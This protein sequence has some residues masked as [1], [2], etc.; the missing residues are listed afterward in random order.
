MNHFEASDGA[1]IAYE[2]TG[3]GRPLVMLHG[4]MAHGGFFS[5]Q[6][7]LAGNFRL[8]AV[9]LRGH[10]GSRAAGQRPSV[11]QIASDV[12]ALA[13]RLDLQGAI[14]VGW[15]LG[16][17]IL[18]QL[19]AGAASPRFAGA[20]V[21]DMTPRV[22][23]EGDWRLGLSADLVK[24][25]TAA[26]R[27]DYANFAVA[28]GSAIFAQPVADG[29]REIAVWAGEQF[30]MNDPAAMSALWASLVEK[31]FRALLPR[32]QQPTLIVHGA[33]S[34]LYRAETAHFIAQALPRGRAIAF[35]R[36][37]HAP[38]IEQPELFNTV[39]KDFAASLPRIREPQ[40][41]A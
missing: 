41:T 5:A 29:K 17:A 16:A 7:A 32:I 34:Q 18:W 28:A 13:E 30:A 12:A 22:L 25:R 31:D 26:I 15:S 6:R 38:H 23:N 1:L 27:D 40:T 14:G 8:I 3:K 35:D 20:V 9:D 21:V 36:S 2:V 4:F 33:H 37:G 24:A 10:G 11:D 39:I 19:L